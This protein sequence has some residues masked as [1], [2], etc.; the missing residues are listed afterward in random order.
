M[1]KENEAAPISV[2]RFIRLDKEIILMPKPTEDQSFEK[3]RELEMQE[4]LLHQEDPIAADKGILYVNRW[5]KHAAV[6]LGSNGDS[7]EIA[8]K[9]RAKT[10]ALVKKAFPDFKV[11]A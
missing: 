8:A 9:R 10:V 3:I 5:T 2:D 6:L 4:D 7:P 11:R 1:G